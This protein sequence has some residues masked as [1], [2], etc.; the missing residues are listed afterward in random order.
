MFNFIRSCQIVLHI[1]CAMFYTPASNAWVSI[2]PR[3]PY[4]CCH[5]SSYFKATLLTEIAAHCGFN[6]SLQI[7]N[8]VQL[9]FLFVDYSYAFFCEMSIQILCSFKNRIFFSI[10]NLCILRYSLLSDINIYCKYF[11]QFV[12][13][14][15][16]FSI[17]LHLLKR[18]PFPPFIDFWQKLSGYI[19]SVQFSHSVV[20]DSLRPHGLQ[21]TRL[22]CPSPTPG[23]YSNSCPLSWWCHPPI[24]SSVV[25]LS[26]CPQSFPA[27]GSFQMSQLFASGGQSIGV[28]ASTSV[29]PMNI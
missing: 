12:I 10:I 11:L 28:S 13:W 27:S 23:V 18:F 8:D 6:L 17:K 20:S 25:P 4:I 9:L 24:S 5:Q 16:I 7:T 2:A 29:L 19:S 15:I 1:A 26:S 21:H 14:Q 22:P 3:P